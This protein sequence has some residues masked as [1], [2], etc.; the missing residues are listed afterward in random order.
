MTQSKRASSSAR[1]ACSPVE[2]AVTVTSPVWIRFAMAESWVT[3]SSTTSTLREAASAKPSRL[4]KAWV[5][6]SSL[7]GFLRCAKAPESRAF[8]HCSSPE[9]TCTGM[10]L[11]AGR[12]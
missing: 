8:C 5:S 3:S 9:M 2:T 6:A 7:A 11:V 10:P 4:S 1:S 12:A